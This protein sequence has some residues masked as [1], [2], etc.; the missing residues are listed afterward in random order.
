MPNIILIRNNYSDRASLLRVINYVTRSDIIGGY[1]LD[2]DH[3]YRQMEM[4]KV[5][6]HKEDGLQLKHFVVTFSHAEAF[7]TGVDELLDLGFQIGCLFREYQMVYA[8]HLDAMHLHLH[9][10]MNTV[11]FRDGHKYR[12]GVAGFW[13]LKNLLWQT[14]STA[15][16]GI[17]ES[18]ANS[19]YNRYSYS[20]EDELLRIG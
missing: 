4:V 6:Y 14:F 12:D 16:P 10:V 20:S 13:K 1:A 9:I 11:S 17:Y 5:A 19:T 15:E 3:A 8:V 7:R 2:P 18:Y